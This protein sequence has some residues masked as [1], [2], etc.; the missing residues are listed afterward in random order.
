MPDGE[1]TNAECQDG[2]A[3]ADAGWRM[4]DGGW[5]IALQVGRDDLTIADLRH[6]LRMR[7]PL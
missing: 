1:C 6:G 4:A 3:M 2:G 7:V 5:R